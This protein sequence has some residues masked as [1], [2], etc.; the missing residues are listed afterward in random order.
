MYRT[1]IWCLGVTKKNISNEKIK[2]FFQ[3]IGYVEFLDIKNVS[4]H[5]MSHF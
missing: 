1:K 3:P 5:I 2:L 4:L